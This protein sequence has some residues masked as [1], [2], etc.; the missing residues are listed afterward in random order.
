[1]TTKLTRVAEKAQSDHK[2]R[3]TSLA[4]L[5]T[6]ELFLETW[7]A[8]N[9]RGA[10]GVD[11]ETIKEFE[12]NLEERICD[13]YVRLRK[14]Q[15]KAPPVRR[16]EIPK[17]EGKVRKLGIP[18]VEDRLLQAAT[19]RILNAIY[20]PIFLDCSY[21]YRPKRSAHDA[22]KQLRSHL[23][24]GNVMQIFEADIRAY[25]DR[26]N[27]EWL[28]RILK[29]RI[30]DPVLLRL[31]DKWLR[32]GV[33][34]DGLKRT[35]ESGVPQGGPISCV[36]S[37]V[38]LHY[39]L[40]L[41]F[42]KLVKRACRGAAYLVRYVDDFVACFQYKAD[43]DNFGTW[44]RTRFSKFSIELAEEKTRCIMFGRFAKE[45]LAG[46]TPETFEFLGFEH[47]CGADRHGKFALIRLP[48]QK[49]CRKFL[50]RVK[51]WLQQHIHW[52]VRDQRKQLTSML[53]GFYQYYALPH[54]GSKLFWIHGQVMRLWR[55][56]LFRR[57]QRS[58]THWSHLTQQQWFVLP[59]PRSL[60]TSV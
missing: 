10:A 25:F 46:R 27:H 22:L 1:M 19:A 59:Y 40:D 8:M 38:Y 33:M 11:K 30:A 47:I 29:E 6:P 52:K 21:G 34:K 54:C 58:K 18:T 50:D 35:T 31:I 24:G 4:H 15:Y 39:V 13:L 45:R 36:L 41:W 26:V 7:N 14:G 48:R 12:S 55:R 2:L 32:A 44:L 3:F 51:E 16:V 23:I 37:N 43:A 49:S 5:L 57:S 53:T 42:E 20:E 28:R 17:G 56:T 60:H 9:K